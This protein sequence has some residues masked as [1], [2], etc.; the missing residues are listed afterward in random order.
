[1]LNRFQSGGQLLLVVLHKRQT[2]IEHHIYC[3]HVAN[4]KDFGA[5]TEQGVIIIETFNDEHP[6]A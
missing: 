2:C 4:S 6:P 3:I 5:R 1:M